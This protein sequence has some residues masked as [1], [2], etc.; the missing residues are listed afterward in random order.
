MDAH[1]S[2]NGASGDGP[3]KGPDE[4]WANSPIVMGEEG[5]AHGLNQNAD[6]ILAECEIRSVIQSLSQSF[7][8][9]L[10]A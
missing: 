5:E 8:V 4:I 6:P 3:N 9:T 7:P 2:Q 10:T 1:D